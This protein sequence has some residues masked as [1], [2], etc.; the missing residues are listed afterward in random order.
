[1]AAAGARE[2]L[3][4]LLELRC[5]FEGEPDAAAIKARKREEEDAAAAVS[6]S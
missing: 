1:L 3:P 2:T 6:S 4:A 5:D